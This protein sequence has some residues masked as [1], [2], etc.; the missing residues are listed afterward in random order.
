LISAVSSFWITLFSA[1][2]PVIVDKTSGDGEGESK[3]SRVHPI[4]KI[5]HKAMKNN[6]E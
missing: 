4:E 1:Q 5:V 6:M 2:L 3:L